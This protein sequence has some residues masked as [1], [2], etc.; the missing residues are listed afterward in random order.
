M[1]SNETFLAKKILM[2]STIP[3]GTS[4]FTLYV[5]AQVSGSLITLKAQDKKK[6]VA[7]VSLIISIYQIFEGFND[8]V[9]SRSIHRFSAFSSSPNMVPYN[10]NGKFS[11]YAT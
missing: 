7:N 3:C 10:V 11:N 9:H 5:S 1:L 8:H 6:W 4:W 2:I